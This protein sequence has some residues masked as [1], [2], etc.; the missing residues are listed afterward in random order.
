MA[1]IDAE[2]HPV[3]E[4]RTGA[5]GRRS[6]EAQVRAADGVERR[7]DTGRLVPQHLFDDIHGSSVQRDP[8]AL[9]DRGSSVTRRAA[10]GP[11]VMG[12]GQLEDRR[13][14]PTGCAVH[15]HAASPW[16]RGDAVQHLVGCH[17]VQHQ[18]ADLG[19]GQLVRDR[20]R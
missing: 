19:R 11:Y 12:L 1:F 16:D 13:T 9:G 17:P 3:A 14:H 6:R 8:T 10:I 2:G 18:R 5:A 4:H 15:Q 20:H 7:V